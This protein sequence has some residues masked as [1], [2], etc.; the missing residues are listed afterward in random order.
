MT[1]KQAYREFLKSWFWKELSWTV[2]EKAG[3]CKRCKRKENLQAHHIRYPENW[4]DTTEADLVVLCRSCHAKEHGLKWDERY[5]PKGLM[6]F[7][8]RDWKFCLILYR[9]NRLMDGLYKGGTLRDRDERFL[10]NALK[11]YPPTPKDSCMEFKVGLTRSIN[12]K[13]KEGLFTNEPMD[14]VVEHDCGV[15]VVAGRG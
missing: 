6:L 9:I 3:R 15:F 8:G 7:P 1:R 14:P 13:S 2:R 4:Y 5:G 10:D 12:Q 11:L